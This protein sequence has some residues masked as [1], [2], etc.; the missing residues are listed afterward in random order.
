MK[1]SIRRLF[2]TPMI[3]VWL[4][5]VIP[6]ACTLLFDDFVLLDRGQCAEAV[7]KHHAEAASRSRN[8]ITANIPN[9]NGAAASLTTANITEIEEL[10]RFGRGYIRDAYA[11]AEG[12]VFVFSSIGLW[13]H[14]ADN[15]DSPPELL[16]TYEI[17]IWNYTFS[18][19]HELLALKHETFPA[20]LPIWNTATG[21]EII[22]LPL[23][24]QYNL[25]PIAFNHQGTQIAAAIR[26]DIYIWD[27]SSGEAIARFTD[28]TGLVDSIIF[29][30][31]DALLAVSGSDRIEMDSRIRYIPTI[32]IWDVETGVVAK[33]YRL[34]A[35]DRTES[36]A[37]S[38]DDRI[39]ASSENVLLHLWDVQTGQQFA[40]WDNLRQSYSDSLNFS[41]DGRFLIHGNQVLRVANGEM[42]RLLGSNNRSRVSGDASVILTISNSVDSKLSV[43]RADD[44]SFAID[45]GDYYQSLRFDSL[46]FDTDNHLYGILGRS[47]YRT[48]VDGNYLVLSDVYPFSSDGNSFIRLCDSVTK[49]QVTTFRGGFPFTF[50]S[51]GA[52]LAT[53]NYSCGISLWD[54]RTGA[55]IEF[56]NQCSKGGTR[57]TAIAFNSDDSIVAVGLWRYETQ[58]A[59]I[60]FWDTNTYQ[61][62][63]SVNG[64]PDAIRG[65]VFAADDTLMATISSDGTVRLWGVEDS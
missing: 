44:F 39:L 18:P 37:F 60:Q 8:L 55:P 54:G 51:N 32:R 49:R 9:T 25:G 26:D 24:S 59:V 6:I 40:E 41:A 42:V 29:S 47:I 23:D 28:F 57:T 61:L 34:E 14:H 27:V 10:E 46:E 5:C 35:E 15:L 16:W 21:R 62:L 19:N 43:F 64:H 50:S 30:H 63:A 31:D 3:F 52:V 20:S 33:T 7:D 2:F 45:L 17:G 36:L 1:R 13:K 12:N 53:T 22:S 38:P 58:D 56:L 4:C 11:D 65:I 48:S